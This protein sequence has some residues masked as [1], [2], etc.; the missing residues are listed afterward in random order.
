MNAIVDLERDAAL[1]EE[2]N[3][4]RREMDPKLYDELVRIVVDPTLVTFGERVHGDMHGVT[5]LHADGVKR[6]HFGPFH[7][8]K[9]NGHIAITRWG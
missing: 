5:I 8:V 4:V 9:V 6:N 3:R 7:C 1:Q 2:R